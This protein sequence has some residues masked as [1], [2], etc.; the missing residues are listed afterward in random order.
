MSK[1]QNNI[2]M[3]KKAKLIIRN[4]KE[5]DIVKIH[6]DTNLITLQESTNVYNTVSVKNV[7]FNFDGLTKEDVERFERK[8]SK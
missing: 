3:P 8:F 2:T 7:I 5:Y 6:F 4:C 1:Q